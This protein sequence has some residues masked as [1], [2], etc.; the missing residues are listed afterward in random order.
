MRML[1]IVRL[2]LAV[3]GVLTAG[4]WACAQGPG[5]PGMGP[6]FGQHRPPMERA[7]GFANG[8]FW[9]NPDVVKQ[10]SLTDDQRKAMDGILQDHRM[11]LIDMQATLRKA[12]VEMIPLM[13]ADSP[14]RAA[15]EAQ[16]DKVVSARA[17]LEKANARFLLDI[18]LQLKP[19]QWK[20]LQIVHQNRMQHDGM[21]EHGGG[22]WG[23][24]RRGPS[25]GGPD[26]QFHRPQAPPPPPDG[27]PQT[28]PAPGPGQEQ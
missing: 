18:R 8:Q 24:D 21:R 1:K 13:K 27:A 3:V 9:N 17:D 12:E 25:M 4:G 23:Q 28:A 20:Q 2:V 26:G 7:F 19:D 11:K 14:D 16:I 6:G 5:G 15:I 10:L 22:Q